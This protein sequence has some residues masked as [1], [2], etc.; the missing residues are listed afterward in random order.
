MKIGIY[1]QIMEYFEEYMA[2]KVKWCTLFF[3][4]AKFYMKVSHIRFFNEVTYAIQ[5]ANVDNVCNSTFK[6]SV[7]FSL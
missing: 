5:L 4:Y 3:S 7:L 1:S 2:K 6:C